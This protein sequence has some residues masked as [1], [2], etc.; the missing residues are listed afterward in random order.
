[1]TTP[2]KVPLVALAFVLGI[3]AGKRDFWLALF[4]WAGIG[5]ALGPTSILA[6]YWSRTTRAGVIAGLVVGTVVTVAWE[7]TPR[8]NAIAC[9]LIPAFAAS[10][11]ATVVVSLGTSRDGVATGR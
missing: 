9:E 3:A 6:L 1:L 4:A 2:D 5:A 8:L 7:L 11:L 10:A